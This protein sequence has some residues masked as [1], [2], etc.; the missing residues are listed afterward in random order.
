MQDLGT[1][2]RSSS[3]ATAINAHGQVVGEVG[4]SST[5][6]DAVHAFLWA[7][8]TM[9][10]LGTLG[11]EI[12]K[13]TGINS[14]GQV[15][16][17][18][19]VAPGAVHAFLWANGTMQDLGSLGGDVDFST[20]VVINDHGQ[21]AGNS[22]NASGEVHAFLWANGTMQDL[23]TLGGDFSLAEEI[24]AAGQ[25]IGFSRTAS[26]ALHAALWTPSYFRPLS[27]ALSQV[28]L[29][30]TA[31]E[32]V[33]MQGTFTLDAASDGINPVSEPVS[34]ELRKPDGTRVY[35]TA[36]NPYG[37]ITGFDVTTTGW[38]I[39]ASERSRTGIQSLNIVTTADPRTFTVQ[40]VDVKTGLGVDDYSHLTAVLTIGNDQGSVAVTLRQ[41]TSGGGWVFP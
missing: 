13:A 5:G 25:V 27:L 3:E 6:S 17:V 14:L 10:D 33:Q 34:L 28:Q 36:T 4:N 38:A 35:P 19:T 9:E 37:A 8:G 26:G 21:V 2:G 40:L 22:L 30:P 24:N 29:K 32:K 16:G 12:S 15:A 11:G 39:N 23:G 1:L 20:S 41:Q 7:D 18:S 31:A